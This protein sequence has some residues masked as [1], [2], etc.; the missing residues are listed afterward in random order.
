MA[1]QIVAI[2]DQLSVDAKLGP[3]WGNPKLDKQTPRQWMVTATKMHEAQGWT[4]ARALAMVKLTLQGEAAEWLEMITQ[5]FFA[6]NITTW[7]QFKAKFIEVYAFESLE[8][9]NPYP[10]I[11]AITQAPGEC[12]QGFNRRMQMMTNKLLRHCD[13]NHQFDVTDE[14]LAGNAVGQRLTEAQQAYWN[15]MPIAARRELQKSMYKMCQRQMEAS[16]RKGMLLGG[17][18]SHVKDLISHVNVNTTETNDIV[19]EASI[20]EAMYKQGKVA[21]V[22]V[23]EDSAEVAAVGKPKKRST[24]KKAA[25]STSGSS[26][27]DMSKVEC[28]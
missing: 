6:D 2:G 4:D 20:K 24:K 22:E 21:S 17:M 16:I 26:K 10:V 7:A 27:P 19:K 12:V 11:K 8:I 1:Q 3:F 14:Q 28:R 9:V 23:T 25:T 13:D 15:N 5:D 18:N